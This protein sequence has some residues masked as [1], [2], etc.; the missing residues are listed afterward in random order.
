[1][2]KKYQEE[3]LE[4]LRKFLRACAVNKNV[5][6]TYGEWTK[7]EFGH[8]GIYNDAGFENIP[9][10]CL[11][12]PTGGGKTILAA[13]A[14]PIA[15]TE[16]LARD[17][18]LVIWL[19]PTN[20]IL[21]QT[22]NCLQNNDHPYRRVLNEAFNGNVEILSIEDA[23][24]ISKGTLQA[25][26][27]VILST[28]ASW[29][30]DSTEGRKV[31]KSNGS[32][33]HHFSGLR[34]EV[35]ETLE[36]FEDDES[37]ALKY[38]LANTVYI[39]N[40]IF[41]IDEAHNARTE[42]T[43]EVFKRLN[44]ACIIEFTAT[45]KTKG[46]DRSNVIFNVSASQLKDENMI[47]MPVE[48]LVH[49]EWQAIISDAVQKR[50]ELEII[51][52]AEE[53][54]TG[55]YLRP[56]ILFQAQNDK[57]NV[58]TINVEEVRNYLI[59]TFHLP[60]EQVAVATGKE[61][62]I[63]GIDLSQRDCAIRY[64]ITKQAL[65]EG[66]DCPF[67]YIFC[68]VAN[69]S[70]GKDVEQLLGRVLRM[71]KIQRKNNEELNKAYAFVTSQDFGTTARNLEDSLIQSG[72]T[73]VEVSELIDISPRQPS[74]SQFFGN[75]SIIVKKLPNIT[76]LN[77]PL[78]DKLNIDT[79]EKKITFVNEI[80]IEEKNTLSESLTAAEDK[81]LLE[82]AFN[83][84]KHFPGTNKSPQKRGEVFTVPQLLLDFE[85]EYRLFDEEVL[86]PP[87]WNLAKC[88]TTLT[89]DEF[90]LSYDATKGLLDVDSGGNMI[91]HTASRIHEEINNLILSTTMDKD[92]LALWLIKE[93][94]HPSITATQLQVFILK[95]V[96]DLMISRNLQIEHLVFS[97]FK[98][99]DVVKN[100]ILDHYKLAKKEGF[101]S[102]LFAP[103]T[104]VKEALSKFSLGK[105]FTFPSAYPA[106][107][108]YSG[109]FRF[110]KHYYE[111][112]ADMNQE[113]TE[114]AINIDLHPN[115]EFWVRN[116]SRLENYAFWLQ[117]STDKFYPDFIAKLKNGIIVIVE[118]K[119]ST[120]YTN[121]DSEE[122]KQIGDLYAVTSGGACRFIML[123][124]K[125]W[126]GLKKKFD[127]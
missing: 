61:R 95:L 58:S 100:K 71:P 81:D 78:K 44:P 91:T 73:S 37:K 46:A 110:A 114:C 92:S 127:V 69:V 22:L 115:V 79:A 118:Y 86:L 29:R 99:R 105:N 50:N 20:T 124:G 9:Y 88:S 64:I 39:N 36:H 16:L 18:S 1:M 47:K 3:S 28:F 54:E 21:E 103:G 57:E 53:A 51:A 106:S 45:P 67:A 121:A 30:T 107:A 101:K 117:T 48:L 49:D 89:Q 122:K 85:G 112:I 14:I 120:A 7:D 17:F 40:P 62:G 26:T 77:E 2:L 102:Y 42:L 23:R 6:S 68:S 113:E 76:K 60:E 32:L 52:L 41:I 84:M 19:V 38:S 70:S 75:V 63:E 72:F 125:D 34:H 126:V 104:H 80:T 93:C 15:C 119:S 74:F 8:Q 94:R 25:N 55:E 56:I 83:D 87:S 12:L 96:D 43:F 108:Y 31:Y 27:V 66:W 82:R 24:N 13:H 35:V 59:K 11:R 90:A 65:K 123:N 111:H 5:S 33:Q 4:A 97:K 98:L 109:S 10:V 116:L